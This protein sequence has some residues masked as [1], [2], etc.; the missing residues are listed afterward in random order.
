[1]R[2][3][4]PLF[5]ACVLSSCARPGYGHTWPGML[6]SAGP[7]PG[8]AIKPVVDKQKPSTFLA[9]DGS[10]CRTSIERTWRATNCM[11][12]FPVNTSR[13]VSIQ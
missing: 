4:I 6:L 1:M 2:P 11:E 10:V 8:F 3:A 9:D 5:A 7:Q 12:L 13:P